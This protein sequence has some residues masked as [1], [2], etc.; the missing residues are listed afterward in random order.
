MTEFLCGEKVQT[1]SDVEK[2]M[3]LD[4]KKY[5]NEHNKNCNEC[6]IQLQCGEMHDKLWPSRTE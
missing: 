6:M 5:C 4:R 1:I 2:Q 3:W